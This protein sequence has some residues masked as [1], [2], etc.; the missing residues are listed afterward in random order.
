MTAYIQQW[1]NSRRLIGKHA[2]ILLG[3]TFTVLPL[4]FI[5]IA[6]SSRA[7]FLDIEAKTVAAQNARAQSSFRVFEENL[8][9]SLGDYANWDD[10]YNYLNNPSKTFEQSTLNPLT[11]KSMGVDVVTYVRFDGTVVFAHAVDTTAMKVLDEESA[12]F[13]RITSAGEFY[14]AARTKP[15]H[16]AYVRGKRGIYVLYSQWIRDS[17]GGS[18][19]K[20]FLVMGN[21]LDTGMLSD[22]LQSQVMLNSHVAV[23]LDRRLNASNAPVVS[24]MKQNEIETALGVF[25]QDGRVLATVEFKTPRNLMI[26]GREALTWLAVGMIAGLLLVVAMLAWGIRN[27]SVRRLQKLEA[28]VRDYRNNPPL[29]ESV[30]KGNDEIASLGRAFH[31]LATELHDA[32][33]ELAQ[34]SYLQG[35][36]DSA[37]GMLHNVRNALAPIRVMQEKWLR[38][39]ALPFRQNMIRAAEELATY[40]LDPARKAD[41][42]AF[43]VSAARKIA[44]GNPG[45]LSEM[46]E[47]KHSV[48]QISAILS[49]YNFNTSGATA[50]D[51]LDFMDLLTREIRILNGRDGDNV[52]FDLPTS[53]PRLNGNPLHL[54]QVIGNILVNADEAMIA[55]GVPHKRIIINA[56]TLPSGMLEI[57]FSDNGDGIAPDNIPDTF[58][59]EYSTRSHKAGGIGLHWSANAMRAMGGTIALESEGAGKGA[60]A[61]LTLRLAQIEELRKAA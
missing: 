9:R 24:A 52:I 6:L 7:V 5:A 35:K 53:M 16:L 60:T 29:A 45:R 19:P 42:E 3:V 38:E 39:E 50:G 36:A 8:S 14:S 32:E 33:Q 1:W 43:M 34:K 21:L 2:A 56:A 12:D 28:F 47:T 51:D 17:V 25:G 10:S 37:A 31:Q 40:N 55:A 61:V 23:G 54:S 18:E 22:A 26:A 58:K 11:F 13:V 41:L 4:V 49:G 48:D 46:E 30:T 15:N 20:G 59:R 27:I 44:L 57:R